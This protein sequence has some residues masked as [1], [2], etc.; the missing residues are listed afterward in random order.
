MNKHYGI[1]FPGGNL[2]INGRRAP[3]KSSFPKSKLTRGSNI[4]LKVKT[5]KKGKNK[6]TPI[7]Q[8]RLRL[9]GRLCFILGD[10]VCVTFDVSLCSLLLLPDLGLIAGKWGKQT[11]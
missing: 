4:G 6:N 5:R 9:C 8:G 11:K 7:K 1:N 3:Y 10:T 2:S